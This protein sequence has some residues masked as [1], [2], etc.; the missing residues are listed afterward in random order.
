MS[1]PI[2]TLL[3]QF[4]GTDMCDRKI[5]CKHGEVYYC[6]DCKMVH[7]KNCPANF[8]QDSGFGGLIGNELNRPE[9]APLI[10]IA[11]K[12]LLARYLPGSG[13]L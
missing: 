13:L 2:A 7:C 6:E 9:V 3:N 11:I 5:D 12:G 10:D 4:K 1:N 8:S